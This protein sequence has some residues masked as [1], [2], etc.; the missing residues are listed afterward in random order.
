MKQ[1]QRYLPRGL[2]ST[3]FSATYP[4]HVKRLA[5][6]F[7]KDPEVHTPPEQMGR[8]GMPQYVRVKP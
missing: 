7:L 1:L 2:Q 5:Q 6:Q 3:M 8:E 4:G